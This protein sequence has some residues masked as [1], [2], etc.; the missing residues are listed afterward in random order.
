MSVKY[1]PFTGELDLCEEMNI[2][3]STGTSDK[4]VMSQKT[5]TNLINAVAANMGVIPPFVRFVTETVNTVSN[6]YL[7]DGGEVV[8]STVIDK[9]LYY[10]ENAYYVSWQE[11]YSYMK[12]DL[13]TPL[14]GKVFTNGEQLYS[15]KYGKLKEYH[16]TIDETIKGYTYIGIATPS[17]T[18]Q[19][20][21]ADSK[22]FYIATE[23]GDYSNFG[24]GSINSLS[25]IKS[26]NGSWSVDGLGVPMDVA[27]NIKLFTGES[28]I[29][30]DKYIEELYLFK[31]P[32]NRFLDIRRSTK[33][34][35][36]SVPNPADPANNM[37]IRLYDADAPNNLEVYPLT[38]VSAPLEGYS[39]NE[40]VGYIVYK[41]IEGLISEGSNFSKNNG[42]YAVY[43][44]SLKN[45]PIIDK[46][47]SLNKVHNDIA[48]LNNRISALEGV[49]AK[50][51]DF[52]LVEYPARSDGSVVVS[53]AFRGY[54]VD[55]S[56]YSSYQQV[57]FKGSNGSASTTVVRGIIIDKEGKVES[58][59]PNEASF[60]T[61][62]QS[63]PIT[64]NSSYLLA[65]YV[66]DAQYVQGMEA[67]TPEHVEV[68]GESSI[69]EL[70]S[71]IAKLHDDV[72]GIVGEDL[73]ASFNLSGPYLLIQLPFTIKKGSAITLSGDVTGITCRTN[74][75]DTEY[76]DIVGS[77]IADRDINWIKNRQGGALTIEAHVSGRMD[78]IEEQLDSLSATANNKLNVHLPSDIYII[79]DKTSQFFYRGF[80][81][82]VDPYIYDIKV[83]CAIGK[84]FRRYYEITPAQI[85]D[86]P[87]TLEVRD[88]NRNILST[89]SSTIHVVD[90]TSTTSNKNVLCVG[91]SATATG[92]WPS[93]IKRMSENMS[94]NLNY[95]GRLVGSRDNS[96]NLEAIGGWTWGTFIHSGVTCIRF[97]ISGGSGDLTINSKLSVGDTI[98]TVLEINLTEGVGNIRCA[99]TTQYTNASEPSSPQ[100]VLQ[101]E[102]VS[103]NYTSFAKE[104]YVPFLN[105]DFT[106]YADTYC[107]GRIDIM[108]IHMG[109][110]SMLREYSAIPENDI[111]AFLDGYFNSFP[112]GKVL[113]AAIPMPDYGTSVYSNANT[114]NNVNRYGT[115][116]SFMEYNDYM[117]HLSQEDY[118]GRLL[119][120]PGSI[121]FDTDY[122]Y[123]KTQ[124]NVNTRISAIKET[125]DTNGMHPIAEGSYLIADSIL[126]VLIKMLEP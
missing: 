38:V 63:L 42:A 7:G 94:L 32:D 26:E 97:F 61:E 14:E 9:F 41:D 79:K 91:A 115:L 50:I 2:V 83:K 107:N 52:E 82:A 67:W 124:K 73:S 40:V 126:P 74:K 70:D 8:Y 121:F 90:K 23:E 59:I 21:T 104:S 55:L 110:N 98:Y 89:A 17:T 25:V 15:F 114:D 48:E 120:C 106:E 37:Q 116:H 31:F 85:G 51:T 5:V 103:Y 109:V 3:H 81:E 118:K 96:V 71:K 33:Y 39:M 56:N 46:Y 102:G 88:N 75:D 18:P 108:M 86:Y 58:Y 19:D 22:V 24:V 122:G 105:G 77:G 28:P 100:G 62:W 47:L 20:I 11:V 6:T 16:P 36:I 123:P 27:D 78:S 72:R 30:Y 60:S 93:E 64:E 112:D 13:S 1:N 57:Y 65:S 49:S 12:A 45:F 117:Y 84:T 69:E 101:A 66:Y 92:Y 35:T 68:N 95:V 87:F 4:A 113:F 44:K 53:G 34:I 43:A 10:A 125:I 54:K 76:Q 111:K 29:P 80:I 119:Y 99:G